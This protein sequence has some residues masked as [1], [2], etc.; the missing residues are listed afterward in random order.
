M[1]A[2][3]DQLHILFIAAWYPDTERPFYGAFIKEH[4]IGVAHYARVSILHVEVE[5]TRWNNSIEITTERVTENCTACRVSI[6]T[7]LRRFGVHDRR[8]KRATQRA[9]NQIEQTFGAFDVV[10]YHVRNHIA[11][12]V[13]DLSELKTK[14]SLLT[15]HWSF[16]HT[17][18][19]QLPPEEQEQ[20]RYHYH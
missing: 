5:K 13:S 6:K 9:L 12:L 20:K 3:P 1:Q 17:G 18:I 10:H 4:A 14:P 7:P 11:A 15:E 16:Y 19:Y 8:V 2:N